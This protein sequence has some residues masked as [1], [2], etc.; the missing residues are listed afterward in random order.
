MESNLLVTFDPVHEESVKAEIE[1]IAKEVDKGLK[2]EK[3]EDG[4]AELEADNPR[5]VIK[6]LSNIDKAKFKY[7]FYW[8][9]VDEWCGSSLEDIQNCI[10]KIQEG[11]K[12]EEKWK[13]D[14]AKRKVTQ[15]YP[16]DIIIKLTE[17]VDKQKVDL[18]NPDKIIKVEIV[19]DKAAISLLTPT[20]IFNTK[21]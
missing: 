21:S 18:K 4:L 2:I 16:K 15:K 1:A 5:E 8:W 17:V 19:S 14:L 10:K 13:M 7:T 9:P 6:A 20:E 11:I 12:P 3:V